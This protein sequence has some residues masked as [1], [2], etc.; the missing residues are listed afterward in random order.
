MISTGN[1]TS[2]D[3][4]GQVGI[5]TLIVFIAMV[6][7]A[8]IA[9]GVLINTAGFL[10]TQAEATGEESTAQV[11]DNIQVIT[12]VGETNSSSTFD[13][14][15]GDWWADDSPDN[16]TIALV[17]LAVQKSPGA[18]A[19]DMSEATIEYLND[20][21]VTLTHNGTVDEDLD[22][23]DFR[24]L[25]E[26]G[27]SDG[28]AQNN[29]FITTELRGDSGHTVLMNDDDRLEIHIPLGE[30]NESHGIV[31]GSDP[32]SQPHFITEGQQLD[33]TITTA[34]GSQTPVTLTAPDI[35][36]DDPAVAL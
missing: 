15:D 18:D 11:S 1:T 23:S 22:S 13:N 35:I 2:D 19:I 26:D 25:M 36:R 16:D 24:D 32:I 17:T 4:R 30:L 27:D 34:Q 29:S 31:E 33:L 9:A 14:A 10:Q 21:A 12:S 3:D 20:E 5:G 6:L 7:V 28:I 8:A